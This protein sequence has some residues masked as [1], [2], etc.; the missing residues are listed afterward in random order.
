MHNNDVD[1]QT[2]ELSY[3]RELKMVH[4]SG[5]RRDADLRKTNV[6]DLKPQLSDCLCANSFGLSSKVVVFF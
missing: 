4:I 1:E 3:H 2:R 6:C 5:C